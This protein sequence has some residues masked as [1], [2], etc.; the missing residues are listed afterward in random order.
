MAEP[1]MKCVIV[2]DE[3]LARST[4]RKLVHEDAELELVAE[5]ANGREALAAVIAQRPELLI[6]DVQ[7]PGLDG[8]EVVDEL[9]GDVPLVIFATAYDRFALRAFEVHA[10]DYL[11]K[12]FDDERFREA[13]TRAKARRKLEQV[14]V[15]SQQLSALLESVRAAPPAAPVAA[16]RYLERLSIAH[17]GR[18]ELVDTA[19]IV[20]I[21]A[22]DQYVLIHTATSEHLLR[23]PLADLETKLDP[24]RFA[25]IH[26][27]AIVALPHIRRFDRDAGGTVK[28]LVCKD[29]WLPVSRSRTASSREKLG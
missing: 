13:L 21:E 27:S 20:W 11:L 19:D 14:A 16:Q 12:P 2:D 26:R 9:D 4:L 24:A 3:P 1:R 6:L 5:C 29:L 22:A 15:L 10:V 17:T 25:R 8:F 23:Q 28:V 18:V 7:M